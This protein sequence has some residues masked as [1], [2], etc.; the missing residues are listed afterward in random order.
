M[1]KGYSRSQMTTPL[2][3]S[4]AS[5][6]LPSIWKR[7]QN[8]IYIYIYIYIYILVFVAQQPKS[9]KVVFTL[10]L[11][12]LHYVSFMLLCE[13]YIFSICCKDMKTSKEILL[14]I[15]IPFERE[16]ESKKKEKKRQI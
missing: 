13:V 5:N 4:P 12:Q 7:T 9:F 8:H 1:A 6:L 16:R 11:K 2:K 15:C 3:Y 14:F 10:L